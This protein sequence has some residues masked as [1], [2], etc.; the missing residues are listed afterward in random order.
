MKMWSPWRGCRRL[1]DGCKFCYIHQGDKKRGVATH[2]IVKLP[3][4]DAPIAK[5]KNG[6]YKIKSGSQIFVCFQSDFLIQE[7]D[8]WRAECLDMIR[9]RSDCNFLFLTKRIERLN[10]QVPDNLTV[11][12]SIENQNAADSRLEILAR[13][14]IKHKII[15][16]QPLIERINIE[17]YLNNIELVIV[18]GEYGQHARPLDYDWVL[19]IKQQCIRQSVPFEFRQAATH[20]IKGGKQYTIPYNQLAKQAKLAN[21]NSG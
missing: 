16:C 21:I 9:E 6:E 4:F 19:D 17:K 5:N 13:L 1:S 14:P 7:A 11:G 10:F 2:Q 3:S 20:F 18:G 8:R 15:A 12:V